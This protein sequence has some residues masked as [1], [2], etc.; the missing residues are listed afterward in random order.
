M[1]HADAETNDAKDTQTYL[2][3]GSAMEVHRQLGHGFLESVY[4]EALAVEFGERAIPFEREVHLPVRYKGRVLACTFVADFVCFGGLIVELK[5]LDE[6]TPREYSQ[7]LNYL[8]ATGLPRAL[9]IN[10][11]SSRLEF[12]RFVSPSYPCPSVLSVDESPNFSVDGSV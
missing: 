5:A 10:F 11:G 8:K 6:L 12:K 1:V 4:Q 7:V 9:L 3:I 2:V